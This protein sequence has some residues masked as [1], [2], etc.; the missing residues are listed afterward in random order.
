MMK[1]RSIALAMSTL[2][3]ATTVAPVFAAQEDTVVR[4]EKFDKLEAE[5]KELLN[6]IYDEDETVEL[7]DYTINTSTGKLEEKSDKK[8][9]AGQ[10]VYVVSVKKDSKYQE[11]TNANFKSLLT[12]QLNK[13]QKG[14]KIDIIVTDRGH[15]IV[16][17]D[18][19]AK[20]EKEY[21]L[22]SIANLIAND[23]S[24][25]KAN[26]SGVKLILTDEN[27]IEIN[28]N[29]GQAQPNFANYIDKD[30]TEFNKTTGELKLV[31]NTPTD[32]S[33]LVALQRTGGM[34]STPGG[35]E[36]EIINKELSVKDGGLEINIKPDKTTELDFTKPKIVDNKLVGFENKVEKIEKEVYEVEASNSELLEINVT[37]KLEEMEV[38]EFAKELNDQYVF[39]SDTL[40]NAKDRIEEVDGKFKVSIY[41]TAKKIQT[42]SLAD[43]TM[44]ELT[45]ES[46]NKED[47]EK[48]IDSLSGDSKFETLIGEN[49]VA[50]SIEISKKEY[51][52]SVDNVVLVGERAIVDGLAAAPLASEK[53]APILLT[54]KNGLNKEVKEEIIRVLGIENG[55]Q[56]SKPKTVYIVG[57]T[58]V[59][60][61]SIESELSKMGLNIKRLAGDNRTET[62]LEVAKEVQGNASSMEKI[63][64]V[65]RDGEAD[66]MSIAPVAAQLNKNEA[67]PILVVDNNNLETKEF[68]EFVKS[69][70][71]VDIIGGETVVSEVVS[72]QLEDIVGSVERVKGNN[73]RDTNAEVISKYFN[74]K[75]VQN[76]YV[77][78]D[79]QNKTDE[80][81]DALS[82]APVAGKNNAPIIL[83]TSEF[84]TKQAIKVS[85]KKSDNFTKLIQVGGGVTKS[86]ITQIKDVLGL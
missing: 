15:K 30:K 3:V 42:K 62:S 33:E 13:L 79:G 4:P 34:V 55:V 75:G 27:K 23:Y 39:D 11:L 86:V 85:N 37:D 18:I 8:S 45:L 58:S 48:L 29:N 40:D 44:A 83:S 22:S 25:I 46:K 78:K 60:P 5:L 32:P 72:K 28:D 63:F 12:D 53:K 36:T 7:P 61:T 56:A 80:L 9:A 77:A 82:I 41:A 64:V 49:R 69:A 57:G 51:T 35:F 21:D 26:L 54:S 76:I 43:D 2:T 16:D 47:L 65:G 59:I 66:A 31:F 1:K 67:T 81:V 14:K 71:K 50:T 10:N 68:K 70:K 38:E 52:N 6:K 73:R 84:T 17:G 19:V 24:N 20:G 74:D